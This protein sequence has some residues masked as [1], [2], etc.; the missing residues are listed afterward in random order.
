MKVVQDTFRS[1]TDSLESGSRVATELLGSGTRP[2]G[3]A[4]REKELSR[5]W[6]GGSQEFHRITYTDAI[7]LLRQVRINLNTSQNG[8]PA[9]KLNMNAI[10]P[11]LWG[12]QMI[13]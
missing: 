12:Q 9:Y 2:G 3:S 1:V 10:L 7:K 4:S 11:P 8:A 13:Q 5:R 6:R